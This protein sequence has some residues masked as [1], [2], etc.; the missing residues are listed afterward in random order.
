MLVAQQH[1]LDM[2]WIV[3]CQLQS[4]QCKQGPISPLSV[5]ALSYYIRHNYL[6]K[7]QNKLTVKTNRVVKYRLEAHN[8]LIAFV[9]KRE[10]K[11]RNLSNSCQSRVKAVFKSQS[12]PWLF[13]N[14]SDIRAQS[15]IAVH[16]MLFALPVISLCKT[17]HY[18]GTSCNRWLVSS[19]C[20]WLK[21]GN[22]STIS[23]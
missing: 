1:H 2:W 5:Q 9:D 10:R 7:I 23:E 12:S 18:S 11:K 16:L 19:I 21:R 4:R 3:A 14:K 15:N 22:L 8:Y 20:C 6:I 17:S 13:D